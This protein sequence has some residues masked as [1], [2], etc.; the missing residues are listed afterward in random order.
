MVSETPAVE[1]RCF[2]S[3]VW[4]QQH[5]LSLFVVLELE[6]IHGDSAP[7]VWISVVFRL[8]W[9]AT[10]K[11]YLKYPITSKQP[12]SLLRQSPNRKLSLRKCNVQGKFRDWLL[13]LPKKLVEASLLSEGKLVLV[14]MTDYVVWTIENVSRLERSSVVRAVSQKT[15]W[16]AFYVTDMLHG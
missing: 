8:Q 7:W 6:G 11:D 1:K 10:K 12:T 14:D 5:I 15:L 2:T 16:A 3:C 4:Q 9:T 13:L